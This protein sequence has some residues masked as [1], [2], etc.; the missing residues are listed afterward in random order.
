M[1]KGVKKK[2]RLWNFS[3]LQEYEIRQW[4][5]LAP[6]FSTTTENHDLGEATVPFIAKGDASNSANVSIVTRYEIH[7]AHIR[8]PLRAVSVTSPKQLAYD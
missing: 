5:F 7:R 2:D 4:Q 8:D 1:E 6:I 3:A